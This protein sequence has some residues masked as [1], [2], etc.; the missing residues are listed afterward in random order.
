MPVTM[1]KGV[2]NLSVPSTKRMN[3][4]QGV[5]WDRFASVVCIGV[6]VMFFWHVMINVGMVSGLLPI[7]GV[8]LPLVSYGGSAMLVLKHGSPRP[9]GRP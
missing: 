7:V 5:A 6:A 1:L 9:E 4:T 3:R 2:R 8:T